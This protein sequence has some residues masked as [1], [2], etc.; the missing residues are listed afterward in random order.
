MVNM[1]DGFEDDEEEQF[2]K[3]NVDLIPLCSIDVAFLVAEYGVDKPTTFLTGAEVAKSL[4]GGMSIQ[5]EF[6][7]EDDLQT[8]LEKERAFEAQLSKIKRVQEDAL[9]TV[10]LG[11]VA[12][13]KPVKI[14]TLLEPEFR[15][16]LVELLREFREVFSWDY[17]DMKGL[18]PQFYQ[19]RIHLK[20]DAIPT[21]QQRYRMNPHMK[22]KG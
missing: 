3:A 20:P 9:E 13:R 12:N 2:L 7:P 11:E 5:E 15:S 18:D 17:S 16:Q 10:Y 19:H 22:K 14:S 21:R 1:I 8:V 6:A 4:G